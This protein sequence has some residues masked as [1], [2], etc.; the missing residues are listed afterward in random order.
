MA[1]IPLS[2]AVNLLSG[3]DSINS[4]ETKYLYLTI[5]IFPGLT[6]I[7]YNNTASVSAASVR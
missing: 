2:G 1:N 6:I 3:A 5:N 4:N 7:N